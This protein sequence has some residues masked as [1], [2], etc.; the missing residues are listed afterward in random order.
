MAR[1]RRKDRKKI[2]MK[3][4]INGPTRPLGVDFDETGTAFY[5]R[6]REGTSV[7][8]KAIG[9]EVLAD[10]DKDGKLLGFEVIG[11]GAGRAAGIPDGIRKQHPGEIP[12]FELAMA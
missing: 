2:R 4:E 5:V 11:L 1:M 3:L 6:V 8:T 9:D 12:E 10:Y 7:V